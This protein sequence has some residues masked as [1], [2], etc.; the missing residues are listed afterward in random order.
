MWRNT[1]LLSAV[2]VAALW[3]WNPPLSWLRD[4]T[5]YVSPQGSDLHS[6]RTAE[7]AVATIQ[8]AA[9][10]V[11]AGETI[12]ILPGIYRE[13][14]RVRRG[15]EAEKPVT[16][17]AR[18]GGTVTISGAASAHTVDALQW[19]SEGGKI[20]SAQTPWP[21]Y[22]VI[23][24]DENFYHLRWANGN[25]DNVYHW[26]GT[27]GRV[28]KLREI[29]ARPKAWGA[30]TYEGDRVY[31][32]FQDGR[33]PQ[34]HRLQLNREVPRPYASWSVRA[35]NVWVEA[36]H[37]RFE[38]LRFVMGVGAG[39]LLWDSQDVVVRDST[40]AGAVSGIAN[41]PRR[42]LPHGVL[43]ERA[44]Y[45]NYP[46]YFWLRDWLT[47]A[48]VYSHHSNSTLIGIVGDDIIARDNLVAHAGDGIQLS[49]PAANVNRGVEIYGNLIA[50]GTD[51]GME[52][53]GHAVRTTVHHNLVY[54]FPTTLG[55]SPV[56]SGPLIVRDN[57]F[58]HPPGPDLGA[59]LKW[60][61]PWRGRVGIE[62]G[63]IRNV[64]LRDNFFNG[65]W[66][67]FCD[68][69]VENVR[70]QNNLFADLV[71]DDRFRLPARVVDSGNVFVKTLHGAH[72]VKSACQIKRENAR[73]APSSNNPQYAPRR[74]GP[75]WLDYD[76]A[77][78]SRDVIELSAQWMKMTRECG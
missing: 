18:D 77:A 33:S 78:A 50:N 68:W 64:T 55:M 58:L 7:S 16:F 75:I 47:W 57:L 66:L 44:F 22:H 63:P 9:D 76:T 36:D 15:G 19:R 45:H 71:I 20:W 27:P 4:G 25:G 14:V 39:I 70:V 54:N 67:C 62:G 59:H 42:T 28:A 40:F 13:D 69:P 52:L 26:I 10:M 60:L 24:D 49:T 32:A 53:D 51:D 21:I 73:P 11:A 48:E 17:K 30:F 23:G 65:K 6:G 74:P 72:D 8:R 2:A 34:L 12:L 5:I 31:I 41:F 56:L 38:G 3:L 46:Q 29:V 61:N 1:F 35:A 37:V 43:V